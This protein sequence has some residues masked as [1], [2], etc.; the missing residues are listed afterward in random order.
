MFNVLRLE[1]HPGHTTV[2]TA[3]TV[4]FL[5]LQFGH[6]RDI[7]TVHLQKCSTNP[8]RIECVN[9]LK[10]S[11]TSGSIHYA[12]QGINKNCVEHKEQLNGPYLLYILY[13]IKMMELR[14]FELTISLQLSKAIEQCSKYMYTHLKTSA[15]NKVR[16]ILML[17]V[18]IHLLL[19]LLSLWVCL[20]LCTYCLDLYTMQLG[21]ELVIHSKLVSWS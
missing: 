12:P 5:I 17:S 2:H 10:M 19:G 16:R 8:F 3:C 11:H 21:C 4:I 14:S 7:V 13:T 18:I 20:P 6:L 9:T 15:I 1:C